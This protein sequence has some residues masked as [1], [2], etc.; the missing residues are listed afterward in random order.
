LGETCHFFNILYD[1]SRFAHLRRTCHLLVTPEGQ[2]H[3][4]AIL[5]NFQFTY[6]CM[7]MCLNVKRIAKLASVGHK[8]QHRPNESRCWEHYPSRPNCDPN[9]IG[10]PTQININIQFGSPL[11]VVPLEIP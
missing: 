9:Y 11:C 1:I 2:Y 8:G 6:L 10:Q 4:F 5:F 7:L 3:M